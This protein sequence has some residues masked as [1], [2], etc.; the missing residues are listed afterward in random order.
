MKYSKHEI[1]VYNNSELLLYQQV[2]VELLLSELSEIRSLCSLFCT[3]ET[4]ANLN[5]KQ[6]IYKKYERKLL[7]RLATCK[8]LLKNTNVRLNNNINKCF[9]VN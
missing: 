2:Q 1:K 9:A 7:E 4:E 6:K 5:N 3:K 8:R